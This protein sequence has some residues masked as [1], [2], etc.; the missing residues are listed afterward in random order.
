M[1]FKW[2]L[3]EKIVAG[4]K[5]Q[6][7]RHANLQGFDGA[8]EWI[9]DDNGHKTVYIN[10]RIK[11]QVGRN[12][13]VQY[14]RGLPTVMWNFNHPYA[15]PYHMYGELKGQFIGEVEFKPLRIKLLDIR[16][17]DV[18]NI[19]HEDSLAEGFSD[20]P[21][22]D[23]L[24]TWGGFYNKPSLPIINIAAQNA[25]N[26]NACPNKLWTFDDKFYQAWALS[27]EVVLP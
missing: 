24:Y 23:F 20:N 8:R 5:T 19:S 10:G 25:S 13:A 22:L 9:D 26:P 12:Y 27:F 14:G 3:I 11:W 4:Q 1:L 17:E 6:T 21:K 7:R 15:L 2:E 18:R 16:Y